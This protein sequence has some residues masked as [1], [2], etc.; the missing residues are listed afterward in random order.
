MGEIVYLNGRLLDAN[1]AKIDPAVQGFLYGAGL[2]ET[3]RAYSGRI[4][5]LN[6][7]LER[8][9]ASARALDIEG[10]DAGEMEEACRSV[11]AANKLDSARVRLTVSRGI[12]KTFTSAPGPP[13]VLIQARLFTPPLPEKYRQGY[14]V[15][16]SGIR[17]CSGSL[18]VCHKTTSYFDCLLAR[19][20]A[21]AASYDEALFLNEK[22][23]LTEGSISNLFLVSGDGT[24]Y[25]PP[26]D[27]GLLPGITRG[28]VLELAA[29][30]GIKA[31]QENIR[32]Q[33][34]AAFSGAFVTNSLIEIM[35]LR[36]ITDEAGK[37]FV[38]SAGEATELLQKSYRETVT[39]AITGA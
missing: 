28:L 34:L 3:M 7:H 29:E 6:R 1:Q 31:S 24:L 10:L 15:Q 25:T 4:F 17:R 19:T 12:A 20:R 18:L 33:D 13:T 9:L 27:A 37:E 26:L 14:R 32:P 2:F 22:D 21:A 35:P 11:V 36:S 23:H 30:L 38:F 39:K 16:I 8:L 5:L